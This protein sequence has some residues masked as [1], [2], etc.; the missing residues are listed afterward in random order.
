MTHEPLVLVREN[1]ELEQYADL[2]YDG[3][4]DETHGQQAEGLEGDV[5]IEKQISEEITQMKDAKKEALFQPVKIDIQ[6]GKRGDVL[7][8]LSADVRKSSSSRP[9]NLLSRSLSCTRSVLTHSIQLVIR[10]LDGSNV[11]RQ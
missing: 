9:A 3:L 8:S 5:D 2:C 11:S 6:C 4:K 7:I 10:N 1:I